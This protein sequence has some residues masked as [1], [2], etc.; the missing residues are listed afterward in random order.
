MNFEE[1]RPA[2][3]KSRV[4]PLRQAGARTRDLRREAIG[5][6]AGV[7]ARCCCC[8]G[9]GTSTHT[10]PVPLTSGQRVNILGGTPA[11]QALIYLVPSDNESAGSYKHNY[12]SYNNGGGF[13]ATP[14]RCW[15]ALYDVDCL[16]VRAATT[17]SPC[18][19]RATSRHV[20]VMSR[21]AARS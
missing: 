4:C 15:A 10:E 1:T 12:G 8:C 6:A 20:G 18:L 2:H 19:A 3:S 17:V 13:T 21:Q 7:L 9:L 11:A 14:T 5:A 16:S